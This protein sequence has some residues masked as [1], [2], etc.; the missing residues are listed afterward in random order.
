M[1]KLFFEPGLDLQLQAVDAPSA[2]YST[3]TRND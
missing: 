3:A 1:T 2:I